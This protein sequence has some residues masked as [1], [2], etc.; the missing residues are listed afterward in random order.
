MR[1]SA[2]LPSYMR[3]AHNRRRRNQEMFWGLLSFFVF[4]VLVVASSYTRFTWWGW[5]SF[6]LYCLMKALGTE[7]TLL[8]RDL[9]FATVAVLIMIGVVAMA[10]LNDPGSMLAEVVNDN[11]LVFYFLG[12]FTVHYF[13]VAVI[14]SN[15]SPLHK[16]DATEGK[17]ICLAISLF[18]LYLL[19]ENPAEIYGVPIGQTLAAGTALIG[20]ILLMLL[21]WRLEN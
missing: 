5:T 8:N 21:L 1:N 18:L 3:N 17:Q 20:G 16:L 11:G 4:A 6:L 14:L 12:T 2:S 9:F 19:H 13:P 15:C 10:A 7:T